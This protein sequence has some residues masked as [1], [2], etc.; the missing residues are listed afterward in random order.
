MSSHTGPQLNTFSVVRAYDL[1]C[2][3]GFD[4]MAAAAVVAVVVVV[5]VVVVA[6]AEHNSSDN[7]L[8][9]HCSLRI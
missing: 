2:L 1:D 9:K 8:P 7:M 3:A 5:V 6:V 4:Q